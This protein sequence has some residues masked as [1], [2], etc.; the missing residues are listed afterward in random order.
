M[1]DIQL[2][3]KCYL[4]ENLI[5]DELA[6]IAEIVQVRD[7]I[8]GDYVF[9]EGA[10][11]TSLFV[12]KHGTIEILKRGSTGGDEQSVTQLS[13]GSH[14]GEMS[15]MDKEPR[16]AAAMAKENTKLLEVPFDGLEKLIATQPVIGVKI[17][18]SMAAILCRRI[19]Q[20]TNNLSSLKE[21]KLKH[22]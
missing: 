16:A 3:K 15:F 12:I 20:T 1:K 18:R 8:H 21:L 7:V 4:F 9:D 14:F 22:F 19:R 10:A 2:L 6:T 17:Y 11:A 5:D 13:A